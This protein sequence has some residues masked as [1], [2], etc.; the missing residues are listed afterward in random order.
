MQAFFKSKIVILLFYSYSYIKVSCLPAPEASPKQMDAFKMFYLGSFSSHIHFLSSKISFL[1]PQTWVIRNSRQCPQGQ[2]F[3]C[4]PLRYSLLIFCLLRW[5]GA[6]GC[7]SL[8][9]G[10]LPFL[11][12]ASGNRSHCFPTLPPLWLQCE[13]QFLFFKRFFLT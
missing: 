6:E 2:V 10:P 1:L 7:L 4:L 8:S 3:A 12:Y 5:E 9:P 13:F 11:I